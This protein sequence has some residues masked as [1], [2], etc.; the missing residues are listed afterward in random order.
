MKGLKYPTADSA[1]ITIRHLLT[2]GA[3][4]PEDNPWGDRQLADTDR[5][6][7]ELLK[8]QISFSNPPGIAYEYA[9]LGFA[10]LGRIVTKVSGM[11]YQK[12]IREK[13][14]RPLRMITSEW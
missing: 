7:S 1:P 10:L 9:N 5:E 3:G 12:Y 4:F 13:I 14:W 11:P 2:H 6:L 8:R